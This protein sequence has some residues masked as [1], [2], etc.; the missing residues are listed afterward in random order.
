MKFDTIIIGG[1]LSGLTCALRLQAEGRKCA[2]IS[3]GQSTLHFS[4]G[5]FDL[6]GLRADKSEIETPAEEVASLNEMHPYRKLGDRFLHYA[7]L[8]ESQLK[9]CGI[10]VAGDARRNHYRYTP[11]GTLRPTWLSFAEMA[12]A[13]DKSQKLGDRILVANFMGFLDFN[14]A[15]VADALKEQGAQCDVCLLNVDAVN[16]LRVSSTEM[17]ATNIAKVFESEE[18][19]RELAAKVRNAAKGYD[20]VV[21]PAVFG[22]ADADVASRL[23]G[24]AGVKVAFIPP[25][26]PSVPGIRTQKKLRTKFEAM[27]GVFI[28]GDEVVKA[29]IVEGEVKKVYTANHGDMGFTADNYV[30]ASGHF[31]SGGLKSTSTKVFEPV[32][33]ADVWQTEDRNGWCDKDFF[34]P[35]NYS[36]FGVQTDA[37]FKVLFGGRPAKNLYAVGSVLCGADSIHELCGAGVSMLTALCVADEILK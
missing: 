1:G 18:P 5:S 6:L 30:L 31:M 36:R 27:G 3:A 2:V 9:A 7:T 37:G 20:C 17:R 33:G 4:S 26:P 22:F 19:L 16:R 28:L 34:R 14:A 29:D 24:E 35:Q 25:M 8:A 10:D 23:A 21:L 15:F 13:D 32:F 12:V 11:M